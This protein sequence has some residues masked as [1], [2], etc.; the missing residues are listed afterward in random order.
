MNS[1]GVLS[2]HL[3]LAATVSPTI[4]RIAAVKLQIEVRILLR[5]ELFFVRQIL[6]SQEVD[7]RSVIFEKAI[8]MANQYQRKA[9]MMILRSAILKN[10][11]VIKTISRTASGALST[12]GDPST[13][14]MNYVGLSGN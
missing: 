12:G 10:C 6:Y 9:R 2:V 3:T 11:I 1:S 4:S 14:A 13:E 8:D 5:F 7:Q